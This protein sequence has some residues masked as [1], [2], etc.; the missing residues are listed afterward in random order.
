MVLLDPPEN[1]FNKIISRINEEE[2][3]ISK[4]KTLFFSVIVL[5]SLFLFVPIFNNLKSE[6]LKSGIY[7][8]ILVIFMDLNLTIIY[9]QDFSLAF[10][11]RIPMMA[12]I[13]FLFNI[14]IFL[15]STK[16]LV[17]TISIFNRSTL[18][19]V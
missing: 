10:F 11:E 15:W 2:R 17:K 19:N 5:L 13:V 1:L 6:I 9:W 3:S 8:F 4:R 7:E 18:I 16:N 12:L 14:S